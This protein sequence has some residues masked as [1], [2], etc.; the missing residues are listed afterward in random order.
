MSN[1]SFYSNLLRCFVV[2]N[3]LKQ[4]IA[5]ILYCKSFREEMACDEAELGPDEFSEKISAQQKLQDQV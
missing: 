1:F 3:H 4:H 2:Q 5:S